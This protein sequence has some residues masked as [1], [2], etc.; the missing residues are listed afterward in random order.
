MQGLSLWLALLVAGL[1]FLDGMMG[2]SSTPVADQWLYTSLATWILPVLALSAGLWVLCRKHSSAPVL[3]RSVLYL[4][5][6]A[7]FA[8]GTLALAVHGARVLS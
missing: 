6:A 7:W 2:V 5:G 4:W 1:A 3:S 8:G